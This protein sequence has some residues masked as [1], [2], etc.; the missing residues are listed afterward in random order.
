MLSWFLYCSV[1]L[2]Q[3][4]AVES[5]EKEMT[6]ATLGHWHSLPT[7]LVSLVHCFVS[8]LVL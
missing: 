1:S 8:L 7:M 4:S 2:I 3:M 6:M 5:V